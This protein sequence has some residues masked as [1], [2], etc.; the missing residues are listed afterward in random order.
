M[1]DGAD[2]IYLMEHPDSTEEIPTL[3]IADF[4][5]GKPGAR[6]NAAASLLEITKTV[7]FF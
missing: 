5:A 6:E 4:L 1:M 7:G 3:D 2:E